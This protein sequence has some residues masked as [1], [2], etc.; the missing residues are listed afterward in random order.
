MVTSN[1]KDKF[2]FHTE[3]EVQYFAANNLLTIDSSVIFPTSANCSGC[4]GHDTQMNGGIDE[5]GN[6][7]NVHDAWRTSMMANSAKDPFW[8]AKVSHEILANP[9]HSLDLQTKCT[10]CHAPQGHYT[11][12]LR[13]AEHYTIEEMLLDSTALDGVSCGTCHMI[14]EENL[15]KQFSGEITFDTN[16]VIYGPY[17]DIFSAPMDQ[18]VGFKPLYSEHINDAGICASCHTL[19]TKSVDLEG[20]YTG[21]K[22]VE[23][24]T[25]HEWLNSAYNDDGDDPKTCQSCHM[26]R[27]DDEVVISNNYLFLDGQSPYGLHDLVGGNATMLKL[28][29]DNKEALNINAE[30]S[31]YQKTID[32]TLEMLIS[33]SIVSTLQYDTVGIDTSIFSLSITNNT[34]HKFP[35]G[36]PSRRAF[37]QFVMVA[38]NGDTLFTSGMINADFEVDGQLE[39]EEEPHFNIIKNEHETQIY[40]LVLGDVNGDFTTLLERS[41]QALKDNRI[42]PKGFTTTH[43]S[44]DTTKIYGEALGDE[45]FNI[46]N[47][48]QGTGRDIVHYHVPMNGYVGYVNVYSR[49]YYQSLP[50]KWMAPMFS[51]SSPEIDAFKTMY[52]EADLNP[53]LMSKDSILDIFIEPTSSIFNEVTDAKIVLFPNPTTLGKIQ[54]LTKEI[55]TSVSIYRLDGK[56]I[57]TQNPKNASITLPQEKGLYIITVTTPKGIKTFQIL[58]H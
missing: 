15:G 25:Y 11:A 21:E 37:V 3:A 7:V 33:E 14:S 13:G 16:R 39:N 43:A 48:I 12:L 55:I 38:E 31:L 44:Y 32:K 29:R 17:E 6:D 53:I 24:A 41:Y 35:S 50:P 27:I 51:V 8:R 26:K 22:F 45:D 23:Q 46:D 47:G 58:N 9:N 20:N 1:P 57:S 34:G 30:D 2:T 36:Y 19:I 5:E 28:M 49:I 52:Y 42:P 4:H 10:S 40:E 18:F 56:V 54:I